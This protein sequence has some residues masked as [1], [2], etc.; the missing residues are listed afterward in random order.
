MGK[1]TLADLTREA[2]TV[3]MF[4]HTYTV[5]PITR[6]VQKKLEKVQPALSALGD[7]EDSDKAV[8][9]LADAID[10]LLAPGNGAP[11]AKKLLVDAWKADNLNLT[12]IHA[13]FDGV[14]EASVVRPT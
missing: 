10:V 6:S 11:P 3:E 7:E 12:Q 2:T 1:I 8:A 9:V 14:Q 13:L 5:L 4:E